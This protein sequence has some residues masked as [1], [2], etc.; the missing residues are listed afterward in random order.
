MT[1]EPMFVVIVWYRDGRTME[2]DGFRTYEQALAV[3]K[4]EMHR[5][6]H[7]WTK[8]EYFTIEKRFFP[9]KLS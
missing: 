8:P 3:G 4:G 7:G 1:I 5:Q 6:I 2:S 9:R